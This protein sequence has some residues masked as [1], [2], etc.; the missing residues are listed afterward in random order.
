MMY[1]FLFT[2]HSNRESI[3]SELTVLRYKRVRNEFIS[4]RMRYCHF[5][6]CMS[7][8]KRGFLFFK[9]RINARV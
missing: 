6:D 4:R 7:V 3:F 8:T 2:G 5:K 1:L 9:A